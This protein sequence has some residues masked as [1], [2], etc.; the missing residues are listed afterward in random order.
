MIELEP[1]H[2][3]VV[4]KVLATHLPDREVWAF[5]SRVHGRGMKPFSD[6]DLAVLGDT[7]LDLGSRAQV[8]DA[9]SQSELPFRVDLVDW[10]TADAGFRAVIERDH[11][12]LQKPRSR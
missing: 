3:A 2:L 10:A 6:L 8:R 1:R 9:F 12:V 7:S 5:G 11:A 4:E